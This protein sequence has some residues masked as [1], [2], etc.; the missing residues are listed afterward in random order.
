M[1]FH[2]H[3]VPGL[4]LGSMSLIEK[5]PCPCCGHPALDEQPPGTFAICPVC[6]WEDDPAQAVDPDAR[7]GANRQSL[8]GV[9]HHHQSR[10]AAACFPNLALLMGAYFHQD[11]N[12]EAGSET[13]TV[14]LFL[15]TESESVGLGLREEM[16]LLAEDAWKEDELAEL[17]RNLGGCLIPTTD[18]RSWVSM[19]CSMT[20]NHL[21]R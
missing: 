3:P 21:T 2:D 14:R 20:D 12:Q 10:Y 11:W 18:Y 15:S 13:G 4:R 5:H 17:F 7:G 19:V 16:R 8:R 6:N 1:V 9:R